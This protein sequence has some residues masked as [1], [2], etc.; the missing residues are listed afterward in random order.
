MQQ[1]LGASIVTQSVDDLH[2]RA[3]ATNLLPLHGSLF[4]PRCAAC[5]RPPPPL[6]VHQQ[7]QQRLKP[8]I[9]QHCG[10]YILPGVVWFC[11]NLDHAIVNQTI[12]HIRSCDLL[13]LVAT[14]WVVY[15]AAGLISVAKRGTTVIES[16]RSRATFLHGWRFEGDYD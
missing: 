14:S 11:E 1:T 12:E 7:I 10:G 5:H 9:C 4:A 8:P 6:E 15:P 13:I 3:G 2:E 16:I